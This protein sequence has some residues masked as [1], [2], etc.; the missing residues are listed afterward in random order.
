[1]N[2]KEIRRLIKIVEDTEI[3]ELEVR[4][5]FGYR[6][7]IVKNGAISAAHLP[8]SGGT[9]V[10]A[11]QRQPEQQPAEE[12]K[13]EY[14]V[15]KSPMV[16]T[17]YRAPAPGEA[18]FVSVGDT[19]RVGQMLCIIEAMKVMNEIE[20]EASGTVKEILVENAQPVEYN[21]PIFHIEEN[22]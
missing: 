1:M 8:V 22:K 17:F 4:K 19:V 10:E 15:A 5:W 12:P 13:V 7:R 14:H 18:P 3:S 21:Q 11:A 9:V 2:E 20:A 16:G 6:I